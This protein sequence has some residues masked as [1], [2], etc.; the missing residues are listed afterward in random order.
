VC[1][2]GG[3]PLLYPDIK[4]FMKKIK[5]MGY[6]LKLDTNGSYPERLREVVEA[7]LVDYVAMDIKN[8]KEKYG[9]TVGVENFDVSPIEE[10]INYLLS[11]KVDF[12]FRTTVSRE[13]H[14]EEDIENIG[15]WLEGGEKFYLQTFKDSGD[16]IADGYSG[17]NAEEMEHLTSVLKKYIPKAEKRG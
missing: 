12:E 15:K 6:S 1:I 7:G 10:S 5:G 13:L 2:T 11:G 4:D 3:E 16:L 14:N 17:Y 8:S 9:L